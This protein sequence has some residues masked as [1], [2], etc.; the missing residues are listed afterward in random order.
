MKRPSIPRPLIALALIVVCAAC[1]DA[2]EAEAPPAEEAPAV[3]MVEGA[4][5]NVHEATVCT[6]AKLEGSRIAEVGATIPLAAIEGADPEAPFL[7]PPVEAAT[8]AMPEVVQEQYGIT[9]LK[10]YWE[11]HGHPPGPYLVPH[12]DFHFYIEQADVIAA[13]DC[14]DESK[15][16]SVPAGYALPDIDIP[17]LGNLIGLC[18]PEMGMHALLVSEMESEETFQG[19]MVIGYYA[20]DPIFFEPMITQELLMASESFTLDMPQVEGTGP[21][22]VLPTRFEA[23]YDEAAGGYEFVFSGFPAT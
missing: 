14:S 9:D 17:E 22:I 8:I 21:G 7:W 11:S 3:A 23:V 6:W 5:G 13:I 2:P 15:P 19:T 16:E 12:F 1:A 10:V 18:V 4:C 20:E